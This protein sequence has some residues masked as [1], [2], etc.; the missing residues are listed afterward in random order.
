[1]SAQEKLSLHGKV[2]DVKGEALAGAVLS[3]IELPD[4]TIVTYSVANA[5]GAFNIEG[6]ARKFDNILLE[7]SFLGYEKKFVKPTNNEMVIIVYL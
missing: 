6:N 5:N 2:I 3:C 4:S 7:V 1:M